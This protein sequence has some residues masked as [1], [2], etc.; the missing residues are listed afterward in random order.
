MYIRALACLLGATLSYIKPLLSKDSAEPARTNRP[1]LLSALP[2][3]SEANQ[4]VHANIYCKKGEHQQAN[5]QRNRSGEEAY[6]R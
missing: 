1:S 4:H 6:T 2:V 3:I 5:N